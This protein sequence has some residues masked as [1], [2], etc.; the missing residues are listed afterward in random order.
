MWTV[1][2]ATLR[3][4]LGPLTIAENLLRNFDSNDEGVDDQLADGLKTAIGVITGALATDASTGTEARGLVAIT[5]FCKGVL[6][7][8]DGI[9]AQAGPYSE[10]LVNEAQAARDSLYNSSKVYQAKRGADATVLAE[11]KI[12]ADG[13]LAQIVGAAE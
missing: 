2:L 8:L 4:A 6:A 7:T 5:A 9:L 3:L 11:A 13:K 10:A 1:I 12:A